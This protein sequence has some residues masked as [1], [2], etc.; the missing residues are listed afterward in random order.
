MNTSD[1]KVQVIGLGYIGLPTALL[2]AGAGIEVVGFDVDSKKI[3][4]LQSGELYFDEPGLGALFNDAARGGKLSFSD[5]VTPA[6]VHII[7]VPTPV[8]TEGADLTYV[9]SALDAIEHAV[10]HSDVIVLESTVGPDDCDDFMIPKINSWGKAN[11]FVLCTERAIP[12]NTIYEMI[13]NDRVIGLNSGSSCE[14]VEHVYKSFVTGNIS[15]TDVKTAALVKVI[16]NSYRAVNIAFANELAKLADHSGFNVWKAIELANKHP[17]VNVL[18]PGPGVGGHC[19]PIDPYFL[20]DNTSKTQLIET[21]LTVNE[22]MPEYV[23]G[24]IQSNLEKEGISDPVIGIMGYAY[25]KDVD[26]YRETPAARLAESL[27]KLGYSKILHSDPYV[28]KEKIYS[29]SEVLEKAE[30]IVVATDHTEY[31]TLDFTQYENIHMLYDTRN[32]IS[33]DQVGDLPLYC[34]GK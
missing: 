33:V 34:L 12:G 5:T 20:L 21:G 24:Q 28:K 14:V 22:K 11:T 15:F 17:R 16:E 13:H 32:V 30:V 19:I 9:L 26:D 4:S 25:K 8:S 29:T 3:K 27:Q 2:I 23:A 18:T 10:S 1:I 6:N 7:C 31:R